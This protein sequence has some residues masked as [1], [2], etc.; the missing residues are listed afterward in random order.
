[1]F[2]CLF[3]FIIVALG[4]PHDEKESL[5]ITPLH[6]TESGPSGSIVGRL[7]WVPGLCEE[8][9]IWVM[10][11]TALLPPCDELNKILWVSRLAVTG[12]ERKLRGFL[13]WLN[14]L[15][16]LQQ[17]L[18]RVRNIS[19]YVLLR[20]LPEAINCLNQAI[21]IYT[22]MVSAASNVHLLCDDHSCLWVTL[23]VCVCVCVCWLQGRFTIAAKHHI[24]IAEI[25]ESELVDIEKV[26]TW[27]RTVLIV[28]EIKLFVCVN[29][30]IIHDF[31]CW[32]FKCF[33]MFYFQAIAHY[34]QAADYYKGEESNRYVCTLIKK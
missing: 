28:N 14:R 24:T 1:M 19:A 17:P 30:N 3:F 32:L 16:G 21:D 15:R 5:C 33:V 29:F 6:R 18:P 9:D 7:K 20:L 26:R 23:C 2:S 13:I 10:L 22:D 12:G 25:Y 27:G 8:I 11:A 31:L 4:R 34:E